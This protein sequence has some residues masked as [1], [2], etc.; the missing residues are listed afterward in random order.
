MPILG[1]I[2]DTHGLLRPEA[3]AALQGVDRILHAGDVGGRSILEALQRLA[4]VT[5][6]R[7]NMDR[8]DFGLSL[9]T[10]EV[11]EVAGTYLYLIHD[12]GTLDLNPAAAGFHAL[13]FGHTH[14]PEIRQK[15]GV[16]YLNPGSAGPERTSRPVTLAVADVEK[17][18]VRPRIV[19]L[20]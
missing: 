11:V 15:D 12:L 5:A 17:G 14:A 20:V 4:P 3:V 7:G 10:T 6:V 8:G 1:I 16:L 9:P 18:L 13:V 19:P 2:S